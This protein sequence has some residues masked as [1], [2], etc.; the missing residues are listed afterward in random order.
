[1]S[2]DCRN[3]KCSKPSLWQSV[4]VGKDD[5]FGDDENTNNLISLTTMA[6]VGY[7]L[8]ASGNPFAMAGGFFIVVGLGGFFV[9]V[10]WL[11]FWIY[12]VM[13]LGALIFGIIVMGLKMGG[14]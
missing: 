7:G 4:D 11:S 13:I 2:N 14:N 6:T 10:G 5:S 9:N 12:M 3:G 8:M 1:M